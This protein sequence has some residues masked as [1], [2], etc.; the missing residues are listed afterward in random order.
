MVQLSV[1]STVRVDILDGNILVDTFTSDDDIILY[2][3]SSISKELTYTCEIPLQVLRHTTR[4]KVL[5]MEQTMT[6]MAIILM[7]SMDS[8]TTMMPIQAYIRN[9]QSLVRRSM[10]CA[11]APYSSSG[12][13][14]WQ[15]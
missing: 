1:E 12:P 14:V 9:P 4:S 13:H 15:E 11:C 7:T 5:D 3:T 2:N 10:S 6:W 8:E